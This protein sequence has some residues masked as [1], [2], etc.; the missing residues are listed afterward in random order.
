MNNNGVDPQPL[1]PYSPTIQSIFSIKFAP[2][3]FYRFSTE[4]QTLLTPS[5]G[6]KI[7]HLESLAVIRLKESIDES[8]MQIPIPANR[9]FK[10]SMKELI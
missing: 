7:F 6:I 5:S 8:Q 1:I 2:M 9:F 4:S 3:S 10:I